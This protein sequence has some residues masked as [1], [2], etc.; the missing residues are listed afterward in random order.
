MNTRRLGILGGT[1]DPIHYGHLEAGQAAKAALGLTDIVV[2]VSN[3]PPHRPQP[4]ASSHHRFAMAAM[5]VAG[6][7]RWRASDIELSVV[8]PS[9]TS[10]TLQRLHA[11]GWA[12]TDL[13]FII[14]TDA[15][16]EIESWKDYPAI[17]TRTHFAVVSR[18]GFPV[19]TLPARLPGLAARM[20]TPGTA[21]PV[22]PA[23]FLIDA[24]TPD[25]SATTIRSRC[26]AAQS[27]DGLVPSD[28]RQHILQHALY[29]S[30]RLA[31]PDASDGISSHTAASRLH[32]QD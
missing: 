9:F 26:A 19:S 7:D 30:S 1:F 31:S 10:D 4:F 28:V 14:G 16:A 18:P 8:T 17:L 25:V 21:A 20:V 22:A 29:S 23:V 5:A 24:P 32:G 15:F 6:R 12:P 11:S 3:L 2:V 27:I 13:F